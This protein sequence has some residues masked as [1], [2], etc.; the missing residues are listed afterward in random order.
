MTLTLGADNPLSHVVNHPTVTSGEFVIWSAAQTNLV[1][2]GILAV[3]LGMFVAK[4]VSTGGE[5]EG[6]DRYLTKNKFA[7]AVEV[8]CLY[9]RENTVRPLLGK[10]TDSF[11]PFLWTMFFFILINNLLGLI[12]LL[13]INHLLVGSMKA[14]HTAVIGG[15]A[16]QSIYVT[17]A[18]AII[19]GLVINGAGIKA[20]GLGGYLGHLTAGAPWYIWPIIIPVEILGTFIKPIALAIRLFANMTAGHTLVAT[21]FMFVGMAFASFNIILTPTIT[22]ISVVAAIAIYFLE[23]F[24]AFLQA[25]IFMFLTTVF[26]SMLE[27]HH[28][29]EHEHDEHHAGHAQ[30]A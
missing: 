30:P 19:A 23:I 4:R 16:T 7:H 3:M 22:I 11:M 9:L 2:S 12:P 18:L 14:N 5:G 8:I 25:F 29:H 28:D 21:L 1:I 26:I 27:H 24:V 10:R 13:D 20:L 6:T 15:T 17:G